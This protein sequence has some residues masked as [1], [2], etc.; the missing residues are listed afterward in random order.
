[1][2]PFFSEFE[3]LEN[4]LPEADIMTSSFAA[5]WNQAMEEKCVTTLQYTHFHPPLQ[6][7]QQKFKQQLQQ[8]PLSSTVHI[9]QEIF[10]SRSR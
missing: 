2:K 7:Q 5:G 1:M 3:I 6:L 4:T 8:P 10:K 9:P